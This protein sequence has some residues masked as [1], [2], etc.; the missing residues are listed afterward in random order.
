MQKFWQHLLED[1]L[2][3]NPITFVFLCV[4]VYFLDILWCAILC[5][6]DHNPTFKKK[7]T[8]LLYPKKK[9]KKK[10]K[11]KTHLPCDEP[12][13]IVVCPAWA[14]N[15]NYN[16]KTTM[17]RLIWWF[18]IKLQ[19]HTTYCIKHISIGLMCCWCR[20]QH[21]YI[22]FGRNIKILASLIHTYFILFLV[23]SLILLV[24][25]IG[26]YIKYVIPFLSLF[27]WQK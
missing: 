6:Q 1:I 11:G 24:A 17:I 26:G 12:M 13:V 21:D 20:Q 22:C 16:C 14:T 4:K 5:L 18:I 15:S 7:K 9:K 3:F 8:I 27:F 19:N 10:K 2:T 25:M 23:S